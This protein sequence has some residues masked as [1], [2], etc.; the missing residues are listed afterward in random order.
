MQKKDDF[1]F[2]QEAESN[3]VEPSPDCKKHYSGFC[4]N[5]NPKKAT[6]NNDKVLD[7]ILSSP[8]I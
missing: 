4:G 8:T 2:Y 5:Y 7:D 3:S 6:E 1:V